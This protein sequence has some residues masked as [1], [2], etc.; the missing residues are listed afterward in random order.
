MCWPTPPHLEVLGLTDILFNFGSTFP[1]PSFS[2]LVSLP[3]VIR[4]PALFCRFL[5]ELVDVPLGMGGKAAPQDRQQ[6]K[7]CSQPHDTGASEPGRGKQAPLIFRPCS[8]VE[9]WHLYL[10]PSLSSTH[11]RAE[12]DKLGSI[13]PFRS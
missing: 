7:R 4:L 11:A 1:S 12:L 9:P 13:C 8:C 2:S 10:V 6:L 3:E 5:E